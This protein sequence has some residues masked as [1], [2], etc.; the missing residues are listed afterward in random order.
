[1]EQPTTPFWWPTRQ[2]AIGLIVI[3]AIIFIAITL[4]FRPNTPDSDILKLLLGA[5][6]GWGGA[7]IQFDYGSSKGSEKKDDF[8]MTSPTPS[9]PDAPVNEPPKV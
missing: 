6:I 8:I 9:K 4:V 3:L 5:L 7:I 2:T 1:M